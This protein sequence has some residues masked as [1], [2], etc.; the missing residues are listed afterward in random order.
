MYEC[1]PVAQGTKSVDPSGCPVCN[2]CNGVERRPTATNNLQV[3]CGENGREDLLEEWA[4]VDKAPQDFLRGSAAKVPWEC[5]TCG[6]EWDAKVSD[7][8]KSV[9]P[10][11]CPTCHHWKSSRVARDSAVASRA[12]Y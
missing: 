1:K 2:K 12:Q 7:H 3:W 5:G 10:T 6:W 9:S 4:H 11:G 8:T